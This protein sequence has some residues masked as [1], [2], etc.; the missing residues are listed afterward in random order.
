MTH[1]DAVEAFRNAGTTITLRIEKFAQQ[2]LVVSISQGGYNNS[3]LS[4]DL[5]GDES[6]ETKVLLISTGK[7]L[8]RKSLLWFNNWRTNKELHEFLGWSCAHGNSCW[9]ACH[10]YNV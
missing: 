1:S 5:H 10:V 3:S 9:C 4:N 2:L 7:T 6:H 8:N